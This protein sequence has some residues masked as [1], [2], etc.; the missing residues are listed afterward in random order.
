MLIMQMTLP[1]CLTLL[2][3]LHS[4]EK[5][6]GNIGQN[7]YAKFI[8]YNCNGI[9]ETTSK[10]TLESADSFIYQEKMLTSEYEKLGPPWKS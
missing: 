6:A 10:L 4:L 1:S 9:I 5:A 7:V 2:Q 3:L 8:Q